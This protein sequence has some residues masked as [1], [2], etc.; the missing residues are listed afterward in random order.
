[1]AKT[2]LKYAVMLAVIFGVSSWDNPIDGIE[3]KQR[4]FCHR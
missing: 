1:M 4:V 3:C 2:S